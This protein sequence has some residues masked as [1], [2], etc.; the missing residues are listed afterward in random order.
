MN[1]TDID[2]LLKRWNDAERRCDD[3][4]LDQ[5]L[6]ED[7]VGVG[8]V[9]FVLDRTTWLSR[10]GMGLVY[11]D[12]HLDEVSLH[13]HEHTTIAVAHRTRGRPHRRHEDPTRHAG[14]VHD[15]V[16]RRRSTSDRRHAVQLHRS[17][18]RRAGM[19]TTGTGRSVSLKQRLANR[20]LERMIRRGKG[21]DFLWL[22]TVRGRR[23]SASYTTPVAPVRSNGKTWL[24]SPYGTVAWVRNVRANGY[25]ELSRGPEHTTHQARELDP[26]EAVPVLRTYLSMPSQR[27]VRKD[28]DI[29]AESTDPEIRPHG[30]PGTR[31]GHEAPSSSPGRRSWKSIPTSVQ[32]PPARHQGSIHRAISSGAALRRLT[33]S[34]GGLRASSR[35]AASPC[36]PERHR[37]SARAAGRSCSG[38]VG[39]T[40]RSPTCSDLTPHGPD[41]GRELERHA[42]GGGAAC[43][44]VGASGRK[45][46]DH[47][48]PQPCVRSDRRSGPVAQGGWI[49]AS[50]ADLDAAPA[51]GRVRR[52]RSA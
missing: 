30:M 1:T 11:D 35:D 48:I 41:T 38:A 2:A 51:V 20:M 22:L 34:A 39:A 49:A 24:V 37:R 8:P 50:R 5:L 16:E 28:F 15:R 42:P 12:L 6:A 19:T 31:R 9:G 3:H 17:A 43:L 27:F 25:A 33:G 36:R 40:C 46:V 26:T 32:G 18:P 13:A 52:W 10:F 7:F 29:T 44:R 21:P 4:A 14:A 45:A 23:T 47:G